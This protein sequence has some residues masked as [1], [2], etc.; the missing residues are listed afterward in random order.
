[1]IEF[2]LED[3]QIQLRDLAARV[4]DEVY[5]PLILE[6]DNAGT[7]LPAAERKR[8]AELGFL[9]IALPVEYGGSGGNL[10]DALVAIEELAK[11][12]Q[13]AAF[14]VFE[15][16]TGPARVIELFGTPEQKERFL[17]PIISGDAT[18][19]VSI[20]EPDAGSAATDMTTAA[21]LE[22]DFLRI[23]GM[24]R[25]CSGG[26]HAEQYLVYV[27]LSDAPGARGIGAVVVERDAAGLT[28]GPQERLMGFH[29]IPSA[30]MFFDD[31]M[32]PIEN[33]IIPAGGFRALFEAF[34]IE[35]LGNATM[36]LAIGQACVDRT[37]AYVT[38]REQFGKP[39]IEFQTVQDQFANMVIQVEATRL[40]IWRA[41]AE[42]G[43]KTP[44]PIDA[45]MAKCFANE[46]AKIVSDT[47]LMLHG[48]YG[49]HP[50]YHI[51]R[52]H[53]D[54]HGW[55]L[56]GGTPTIQRT[57]IVSQYLGRNFNQRH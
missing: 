11:R 27:R 41:A 28:F 55:A 9:G 22:G 23:N 49:Y 31:V 19:A 51:E 45:S 54:A 42:A 56:G 24:K 48:G 39:I 52:Y 4:A 20:S 13:I 8:L 47:A 35:R 44:K 43:T 53:R 33:M 38:E 7:F 3:S 12:N 37:A 16:N 1:V 17:P 14:Q 29:G 5:A 10:L 21:T 50:E 26:G 2:K 32:V 30:D 57:R 18:L 15:A 34:S 36:S 25:W 46:M 6:W 40:L